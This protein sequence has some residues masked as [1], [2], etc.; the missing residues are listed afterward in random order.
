MPSTEAGA[1][2]PRNS[3]R[4]TLPRAIGG[5]QPVVAVTTPSAAVSSKATAAG[6]VDNIA[7]PH[8]T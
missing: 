8:Q 7:H 3:G 5:I 4:T 2:S 1:P 6:H